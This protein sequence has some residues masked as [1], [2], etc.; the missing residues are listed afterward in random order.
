MTNSRRNILG[1]AAISG[2]AV[3]LR[4]AAATT[5]TPATA[6][7]V[8]LASFGVVGDGKTDNSAAIAAACQHAAAVFESGAPAY[9]QFPS[10]NFL[11]NK[12][13][14]P[15]FRQPIGIKGQGPHQTTIIAGPDFYGDIFAWSNCWMQNVYGTDT[16]VP[17]NYTGVSV[18]DIGFTGTLGTSNRVNALAFYDIN[19][20]VR[21]NNV[22]FNYIPGHAI[23][24]GGV[25]STSSKYGILRESRFN[26]IRIFQSGTA[27]AP[28]IQ[29]GST[30]TS[31]ASNELIFGEIDI[32]WP[33]GHGF[34][35]FNSGTEPV[36]LIK[37]IGLRV[38]KV[39]SG[40]SGLQL[41]GA[42]TSGLVYGVNAMGVELVTCEAGSTALAISGTSTSQVFCCSVQGQIVNCKGNGIVVNTGWGNRISL[43]MNETNGTGLTVTETTSPLFYDCPSG[44]S[45]YVAPGSQVLFASYATSP[46]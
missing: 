25:S 3:G 36:R 39:L 8:N 43:L 46:P 4:S 28:C 44:S 41:G 7:A 9:L 2:L 27:N 38:E 42:G 23:V 45:Y 31:D 12:A 22:E 19:D 40:F 18:Q 6:G 15:L 13:A 26:E 34:L 29:I 17:P 16:L 20:F 1:A 5:A 24:A 11:M 10:G 37:I 32:F 33:R 21:V 30:G 14:S 35:I